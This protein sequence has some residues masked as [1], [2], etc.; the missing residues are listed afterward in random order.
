MIDWEARIKLTFRKNDFIRSK[1]I[2]KDQ[3]SISIMRAGLF[4]ASFI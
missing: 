3:M 1:N 4:A 2:F